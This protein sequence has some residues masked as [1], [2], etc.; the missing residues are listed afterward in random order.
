MF[1]AD[2][3]SRY[4]LRRYYAVAVDTSVDTLSAV[5]MSKHPSH[6]RHC[7]FPHIVAGAASSDDLHV[8]LW[9]NGNTSIPE[10]ENEGSPASGL[11]VLSDDYTNCLRNFGVSIN[12]RTHNDFASRM[13]TLRVNILN[14]CSM[15]SYELIAQKSNRITIIAPGQAFCFLSSPDDVVP[16]EKS[17]VSFDRRVVVA[18]VYVF[19]RN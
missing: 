13:G 11:L 8:V 16:Q 19:S 12:S 18:V 5:S 17:P 6:F 4:L 15:Y 10:N 1:D 14:M 2:G 9:L 7:T 3:T